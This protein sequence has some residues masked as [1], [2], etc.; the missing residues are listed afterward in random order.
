MIFILYFANLVN[1]L[2]PKAL[3]IEKFSII[4]QNY[5]IMNLKQNDV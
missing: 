5:G 2:N 1:N 3:K 4:L